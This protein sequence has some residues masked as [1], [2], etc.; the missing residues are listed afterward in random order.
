MNKKNLLIVFDKYIEKFDVLNAQP[1]VEYYKWQIAYVFHNMMSVALVSSD[2]TFSVALLKVKKLTENIIDNFTTP[3]YGLCKL[4]VIEP[5]TVKQLFVD[6]Y[7]CN[8]DNVQDCQKKIQQFI[9][10]S[11]DLSEKYYPGSYLYKNDLHSTIAFLFLNDPDNFYLFKASHCNNFA[12]CIGFVESWGSKNDF[13]L[14]I[15]NKMCDQV[16]REIKEYPPL[17]EA[18]EKRYDG[19]FGNDLH[20]D[21]KL[22]ILLFDLIYCCSTYEFFEG[23]SFKRTSRS[24]VNKELKSWQLLAGQAK[25]DIEKYQ[26]QLDTVNDIKTKLC[27]ELTV[28]STISHK[29]YGDVIVKDIDRKSG[30]AILEKQDGSEIKLNCVICCIND[31]LQFSDDVAKTA[32][33]NKDILMNEKKI[34]QNLKDA[35]KI[36]M[37]YGDA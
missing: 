2:E 26:N 21:T 3:F 7:S 4:A 37:L 1:H 22:H 8:P 35:N 16:I 17:L 19:R 36:L 31:I 11:N 18:N 25:T 28:G 24:T 23:M 14:S 12:D 30:F 32:K 13:D 5:K 33:E 20:P 6:L 15:F 10:N 34:I 27:S 9:K 29:V